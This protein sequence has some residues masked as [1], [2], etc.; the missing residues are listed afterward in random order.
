MSTQVTEHPSHWE[1]STI[2]GQGK[3]HKLPRLRVMVAKGDPAA[4]RAEIIKQA[5]AAR[6][7]FGLATPTEDTVV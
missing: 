3:Q 2:I 4:L 1:V 5:E 7:V 6:K